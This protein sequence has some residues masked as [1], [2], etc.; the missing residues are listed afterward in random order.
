M[1]FNEFINKAPMTRKRDALWQIIRR[2]NTCKIWIGGSVNDRYLYPYRLISINQ[3]SD[4]KCESALSIILD[5]AIDDPSW[6]NESIIEK[7]IEYDVQYVVPKDYAGDIKRTIASIKE[8]EQLYK[9]SDCK[10][11]IIVPIQ[12]PHDEMYE[13]Y[14]PFLNEYSHYCI[15]GMKDANVTDQIQAVDDFRAVAGPKKW[16]HGLGMG[17][18]EE[19]I[20]ALK[21]KSP[22]L[23]SIDTS[24][25][26][27]IP[28]RYHKIADANWDQKEIEFPGDKLDGRSS[29]IST[30]QAIL[31]EWHVYLAN[32]QLSGLGEGLAAPDGTTQS[33]LTGYT[34]ET[35]EQ[36]APAQSPKH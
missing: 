25:F 13:E 32:Y 23:D 10:A 9:E 1:N 19:M 16:V 14:K 31:A 3:I 34:E 7:A 12:P 29:E 35:S 17:C 15:G 33:T 22:F 24:T 2:N 11:K 18:S 6:D 5:S 28:G 21:T 30:M 8:F 20:K 26:E 36:S 4:N 27:S